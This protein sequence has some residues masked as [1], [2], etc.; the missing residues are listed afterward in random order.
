MTDFTVFIV[1]A[2]DTYRKSVAAFVHSLGL[3]SEGHPSVP[4]F[5]SKF[6]ADRH[7]CLVLDVQ[8]SRHDALSLQRRLSATGAVLPIV[9]TAG[10]AESSA[11]GKAIHSVATNPARWTAGGGRAGG[12]L[13]DTL[14]RLPRPYHRETNDALTKRATTLSRREREVMDLALKGLTSKVIAKELT[15]SHRTVEKHR[16]RLLEKMG[17]FSMLELLRQ[18][19]GHPI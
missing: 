6:T 19:M 12:A 1:D 13:S 15:I 5:L 10:L 8:L 2:S 9:F 11:A 18:T 3:R 17:T 7:G 4:A 14:R 16:S